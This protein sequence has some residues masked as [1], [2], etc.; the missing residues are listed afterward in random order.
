M[1]ETIAQR[2]SEPVASERFQDTLAK[3][4]ELPST[5]DV[6]AR[7]MPLF[8][9]V[10]AVHEAN[11]VAPLEGVEEV[12][13]VAG[14]LFFTSAAAEDPTRDVRVAEYDRQERGALRVEGRFR[15]DDTEGSADLSIGDLETSSDRPVF[16]PRYVTWEHVMGQHDPLTDIFSLGMIAASV[17]LDA[18]LGDAEELRR[19]VA[20]STRANA[21]TSCSTSRAA[22]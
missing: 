15:R 2:A 14:R 6:L 13:A 21:S 9:Q 18:D 5:D 19:F 17:A 3:N 11:R 16:L 12:R 1:T 20:R 10:A 8:E 4:D 7:I 22:M